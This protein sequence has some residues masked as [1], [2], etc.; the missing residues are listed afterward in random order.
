LQLLQLLLDRAQLSLSTII[1]SLHIPHLKL[2]SQQA[3]V[4]SSPQASGKVLYTPHR[5]P[6][7]NMASAAHLKIGDTQGVPREFQKLI[8]GDN[9]TFVWMQQTGTGVPD[10][11]IVTVQDGNV[12][13]YQIP[14]AKMAHTKDQIGDICKVSEGILSLPAGTRATRTA[15]QS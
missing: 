9:G 14:Q 8:S 12:E 15:S 1:L 6:R 10:V 2:V 13:M 7:N 4:E 11:R 3:P 5:R